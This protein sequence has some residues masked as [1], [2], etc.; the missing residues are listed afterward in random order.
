MK[1]CWAIAGCNGAAM[2]LLKV[3]CAAMLDGAYDV[4]E[5][6]SDRRAKQGEDDD[7]YYCNKNKN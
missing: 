5:D 3:R 2:R 7:N 1:L 6:I 4:T